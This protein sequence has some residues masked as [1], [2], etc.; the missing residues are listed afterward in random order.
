M[1]ESRSYAKQV[2]PALEAYDAAEMLKP[3]V[4]SQVSGG[5]VAEH[6][7]YAQEVV[8]GVHAIMVLL[9]RNAIAQDLGQAPIVGNYYASALLRLAIRSAETLGAD[10]DRLQTFITKPTARE[11]H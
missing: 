1:D 5:V 9:E 3:N 7:V 4:Q 2:S 6:L 11:V 10:F 8:H